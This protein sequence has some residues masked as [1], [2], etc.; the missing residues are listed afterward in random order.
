MVKGRD[1]IFPTSDPPPGP[2]Y[3][4]AIDQGGIISGMKMFSSRWVNL[5]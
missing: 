5:A 1:L 2:K 4:T 3:Y